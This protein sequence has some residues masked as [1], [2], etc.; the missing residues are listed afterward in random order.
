MGIHFKNNINLKAFGK[1]VHA[2]IIATADRRAGIMQDD[3]RRGAP[4]TDRTG[5]ARQGLF[6]TVDAGDKRISIILAHTMSYGVFLELA[7]GG[8]YQIILPTV[9]SNVKPLLEDLKAIFR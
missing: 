2:G 7:N 1:R 9:A 5:N 6:G 4:W 8:K 3:A